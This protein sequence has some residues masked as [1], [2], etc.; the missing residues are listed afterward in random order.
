MQLSSQHV[1]CSLNRHYPVEIFS[2]ERYTDFVNRVSEATLLI[3]QKEE[4]LKYKSIKTAISKFIYIG[5]KCTMY[6]SINIEDEWVY[7]I[8]RNRDIYYPWNLIVK[9]TEGAIRVTALLDEVIFVNLIF[10]F[11]KN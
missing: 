8:Y 2:F 11:S 3:Q 5:K 4:F 1:L 9:E 6:K 10:S 7:W